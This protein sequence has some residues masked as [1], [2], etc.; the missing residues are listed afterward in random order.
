MI[1]Q[2]QANKA[3]ERIKIINHQFFPQ[4]YESK[5]ILS[6]SRNNWMVPQNFA[7]KI[8]KSMLSGFSFTLFFST[9]QSVQVAPIHNQFI[10]LD[11]FSNS[12]T[13]DKITVMIVA[14]KA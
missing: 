11:C 1:L 2:I 14:T 9:K 6:L 4:P 7:P 10:H 5:A 13:K 3:K 8:I 12:P